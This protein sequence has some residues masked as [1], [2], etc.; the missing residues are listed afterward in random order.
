MKQVKK[1]ETIKKP[2]ALLVRLTDAGKLLAGRGNVPTNLMIDRNIKRLMEATVGIREAI[3]KT[4]EGKAYKAALSPP[5]QKNPKPKSKVAAKKIGAPP[6]R[7]SAVEVPKEIT[8]AFM[9]KAAE[10]EQTLV[11][12][13]PYKL[14]A[15]RLPDTFGKER[16]SDFTKGIRNEIERIKGETCETEDEKKANEINLARY[17]AA[18]AANISTPLLQILGDVTLDGL[19]RWFSA[20]LDCIEGE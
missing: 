20:E 19:F 2:W 1:E 9:R 16:L 4:E 13:K 7:P 14:S 8:D 3:E 5:A 11:D 12:F 10:L 18:L 15:A 17:E 6:P